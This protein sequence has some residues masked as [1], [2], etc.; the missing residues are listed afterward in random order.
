MS[1]LLGLQGAPQFITNLHVRASTQISPQGRKELSPA[2]GPGPGAFWSLFR[3]G[4]PLLGST[5]L[6]GG[7]FSLPTPMPPHTRSP[8][9]MPLGA[10]RH[11]SF[12]SSPRYT[13]FSRPR[14]HVVLVLLRL[15]GLECW[16]AQLLVARGVPGS[17][18]PS[19]HS[20][21]PVSCL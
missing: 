17:L 6:K 5:F 20:L 14:S 15:R 10:P 3:D 11:G 16:L 18:P 19:S 9:W 4:Q 12:P 21:L 2:P 1:A 13:I 8:A 7:R